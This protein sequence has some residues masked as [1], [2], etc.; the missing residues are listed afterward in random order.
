M[1]KDL[2]KLKI[3]E[4]EEPIIRD[5]NATTN[6]KTAIEKL[7]KATMLLFRILSVLGNEWHPDKKLPKLTR[8]DLDKAIFDA[9]VAIQDLIDKNELAKA[10]EGSK[11]G[12]VHK[13]GKGIKSF[14]VNLKPFLK[15][16]LA[17]AVQGAA[18]NPPAV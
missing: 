7:N 10:N 2:E 3:T 17:V 9:E 1:Q 4:N 14:C 8:D 12:I 11:K 16:F 5:D 15:T 13:F 6:I 18:V